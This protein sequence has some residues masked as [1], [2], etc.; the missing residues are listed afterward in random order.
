M[1]ETNFAGLS[2]TMNHIEAWPTEHNVEVKTINTYR[3]IVFD[4][5]VD[6]FLDAE[7][8]ISRFREIV[9]SQFV[10]ANLLERR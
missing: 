8:E 10:F 6:V 2:S 1:L 4:A 9:A 7:T 3:R 5:Q